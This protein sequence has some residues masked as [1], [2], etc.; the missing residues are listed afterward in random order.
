MQDVKLNEI[1][2]VN[3]RREMSARK[4]TAVDLAKRC[5]WR[6]PRI[7]EILRAD[8]SP[9]LDTVEQIAR[10]ID[11]SPSALLL[12]VPENSLSGALTS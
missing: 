6:Q 5:G 9:T 8:H 7:S 4:L 11:I 10:A 1:L 3:L 2:A 12:P